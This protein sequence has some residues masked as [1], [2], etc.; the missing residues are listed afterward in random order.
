MRIEQGERL[1]LEGIAAAQKLRV[2]YIVVG[3]RQ[4]VCLRLEKKE[5]VVIEAGVATITTRGQRYLKER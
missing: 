5:L 3:S 2:N 4:D 1:A